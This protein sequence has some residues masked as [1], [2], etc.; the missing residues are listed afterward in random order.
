MRG[1]EPCFI[2]RKYYR[3]SRRKIVVVQLS[4]PLV[5][6]YWVVKFDLIIQILARGEMT[7]RS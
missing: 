4:L 6:E 3:V 2:T 5:Y 1:L 7:T